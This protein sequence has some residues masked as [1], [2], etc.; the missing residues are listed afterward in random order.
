[1]TIQSVANFDLLYT[2][3]FAIIS[4]KTIV[5]KCDD[6]GRGRGVNIVQNCDDPKVKFILVHN[7]I[8]QLLTIFLW[9]TFLSQRKT[10]VDKIKMGEPTRVKERE[11]KT[12]FPKLQKEI[13]KGFIPHFY[14]CQV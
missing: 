7:R 6:R 8:F 2:T 9:A 12:P 14:I 5:Q 11:R 3:N 13:G 1:M 10:I 4:T